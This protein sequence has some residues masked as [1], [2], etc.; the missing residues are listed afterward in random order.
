MKTIPDSSIAQ[1]M[2]GYT[3]VALPS[4]GAKRQIAGFQGRLAS[5]F[6]DSIW[7]TPANQLHFTLFEIIQPAV[8]YPVDKISLFETFERSFLDA[9]TQTITSFPRL[10]V[11]F[12][13]IEASQSAVIVRAS[14]SSK[15]N[16]IRKRVMEVAVLPKA[17][18]QPPDITHSSIARYALQIDLEAVQAYATK[19][20]I[21]FQEDINKFYL[22][23]TYSPPLGNYEILKT[24]EL[25]PAH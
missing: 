19:Y 6:P 5:Q 8:S 3:I 22:L 4:K 18:R 25:F 24:F 7:F 14:D 20:N 16:E 12:D 17:T 21:N 13:T 1:Q 15:F 23:K 2:I 10:S 11:H 9:T